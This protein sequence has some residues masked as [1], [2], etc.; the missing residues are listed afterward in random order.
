MFGFCNKYKEE[1]DVLK[2]ALKTANQKKIWLY[3]QYS[4]F[5]VEE[6]QDRLWIQIQEW[7]HFHNDILIFA[8]IYER[9]RRNVKEVVEI[10]LNQW[11]LSLNSQFYPVV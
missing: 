1:I 3:N 11:S 8:N 9:D 6:M 10:Y 5:V 7:T 4:K 2:K